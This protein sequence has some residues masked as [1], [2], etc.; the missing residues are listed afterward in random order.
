MGARALVRRRMAERSCTQCG[1]T[2]EKEAGA[3]LIL[4]LVFLVA[5]S[6]LAFSLV[7]LAGNNLVSTVQFKT[8][9]ATQSATNNVTDIALNETRYNF[10]LYLSNNSTPYAC[11]AQDVASATPP[12]SS[13]I[14]VPIDSG[15]NVNV[16]AW[17]TMTFD[18]SNQITRKVTI[19][20]CPNTV[21][22]GVLCMASPMTKTIATFDDFPSTLGGTTCLPGTGV[23]TNPNSTCGNTMSI[24]SWIDRNSI[25]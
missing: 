8:A 17:C 22:S 2:H 12:S 3:S 14:S 1:S 9:Q 21:T 11:W 15:T 24:L 25:T 19:Y 10:P 13:S 6:L 20:S 23:V 5:V 4:A 16:S 18:P 7:Q